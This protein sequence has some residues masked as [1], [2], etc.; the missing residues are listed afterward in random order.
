M[1]DA[2]GTDLCFLHAPPAF[3]KQRFLDH[4]ER[5]ELREAAKALAESA[6]IKGAGARDW[7]NKTMAGFIPKPGRIAL[8][9]MITEKGRLYGDLT[10][11]CLADDHFMLF[12]SGVMQDAHSRFF[13]KTLPD[14]VTH[15]NQTAQ[16]HGIALSG[17]KSRELLSRITRDD[18][19]AEGMKFRD[20]RETFV[21]GVPVVLNRISFSGELP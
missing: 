15:E 14:G 16:W 9:P 1:T 4:C 17:P 18:V 8:T 12:G 10:V 19:S 5:A 13:A 3:F 21:G 11:A 2:E 7:L 20:C 6:V